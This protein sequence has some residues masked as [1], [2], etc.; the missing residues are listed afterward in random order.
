VPEAGAAARASVAQAFAALSR[1]GIAVTE[2]ALGQPTLDEVF[3]A[4]TG[5]PTA[6]QPAEESTE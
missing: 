3:L 5:H 2:F 4:L 1:A 6:D